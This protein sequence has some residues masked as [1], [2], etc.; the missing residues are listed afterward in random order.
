MPDWKVTMT[1][2]VIVNGAPKAIQA[3]HLVE[4]TSRDLA[5]PV[6]ID[7]IF[8]REAEKGY[9]LVPKEADDYWRGAQRSGGLLYEVLSELENNWGL[10]FGI[11]DAAESEAGNPPPSSAH[12]PR[13]RN[14]ATPEEL[15]DLD[16]MLKH[17][18]QILQDRNVTLNAAIDKATA[19]RDRNEASLMRIVQ[20]LAV[21]SKPDP[22][23]PTQEEYK[24]L[25]KP[26]TI[27]VSKKRGRPP[28]AQP[29]VE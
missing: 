26:D 6:G 12:A 25:Q 11:A 21:S 2:T 3:D 19:E 5:I 18:L 27:V 20:F 24:E 17:Q 29:H 23:M 9:K 8:K 4:G 10:T 28:K 15:P 13:S 14:G 16:T 22:I 7:E 1:R